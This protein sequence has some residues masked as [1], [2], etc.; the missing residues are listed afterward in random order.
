M[1]DKKLVFRGATAEAD[2]WE[3]FEMRSEV[4]YP[5]EGGTALITFEEEDGESACFMFSQK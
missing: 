1:P 4:I 5:M 3:M 2:D